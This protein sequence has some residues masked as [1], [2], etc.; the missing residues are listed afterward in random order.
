MRGDHGRRNGPAPGRHEPEHALSGVEGPG[1]RN[2]LLIDVGGEET[3][4]AVGAGSQ[5]SRL[6]LTWGAA[7]RRDATALAVVEVDVEFGRLP[8]YRV[9]DR[10]LWL[11]VKH[12][13]LHACPLRRRR[14]RIR[15]LAEHWHARIVEAANHGSWA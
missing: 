15:A 3:A 6:L 7:P 12:P 5:G 13:T 10:K 4:A 11:G 2:A 9:V 14:D 1:R 8:N